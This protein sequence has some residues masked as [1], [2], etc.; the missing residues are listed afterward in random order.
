MILTNNKT[1]FILNDK[2]S[3]PIIMVTTAQNYDICHISELTPGYRLRDGGWLNVEEDLSTDQVKKRLETLDPFMQPHA[4]DTHEQSQIKVGLR[5]AATFL[6]Q[7]K[8]NVSE[9]MTSFYQDARAFLRAMAPSDEEGTHHY[10]IVVGFF[11]GLFF[12]TRQGMVMVHSLLEKCLHEALETTKKILQWL[13]NEE[14]EQTQAFS[15][16]RRGHVQGA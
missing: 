5:A 12:C 15:Q 3:R 1:N 13:Q 11:A 8:Y 4:E 9:A 10:G 6:K 14:L 7:H 2:T 16:K